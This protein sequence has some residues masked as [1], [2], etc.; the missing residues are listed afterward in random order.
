[1]TALSAPIE[2]RYFKLCRGIITF[3]TAVFF[4][5]CGSIT[6]S[7]PRETPEQRA[8]PA[9]IEAQALVSALKNQNSQLKSFKGIGK[10]K[11][12]QNG[13]LKFNE[14][15]VWIGSE[16][17]KLSIVI[18][19]SGL[20]A[21]KMTSDGEWFYYYEARQDQPLFEKVRA[22]DSVLKRLISI[23]VKT[24]DIVNL[25]AGRVP[26]REHHSA[27]LQKQRDG[28]GF[29]LV[30]KKRWHGVVEKILFD[31]ARSQVRQIEFYNRQGALMYFARFD[32]MQTVNEYQVPSRLIIANEEGADFQLDVDRYWADVD[33][34]ASMFVLNPPE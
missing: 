3:I 34:T 19:I 27:Y 5:G 25:L 33:V 32:E 7:L 26:L 11:I 28:S 4:V 10:I 20:P 13:N 12:R 9:A 24:S 16:T 23:P 8:D 14:R 31:E 2:A 21:V 29:V 1:M 30:L 22:T 6:A 15:I 17:A 18:L